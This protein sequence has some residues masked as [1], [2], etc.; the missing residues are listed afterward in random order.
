MSG[1]ADDGWVRR[2]PGGGRWRAGARR[3]VAALSGP[4]HIIRPSPDI[5]CPAAGRPVPGCCV[6]GKGCCLRAGRI[7]DGA[8]HA[9]GRKGIAAPSNFCLMAHPIPGC[10]GHKS[11]GAW[12]GMRAGV[13]GMLGGRKW[14]V[15]GLGRR[16]GGARPQL[17]SLS[18][19]VGLQVGKS[20]FRTVASHGVQGM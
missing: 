14:M 16:G 10:R 20:L 12:H 15:G 17:P 1:L 2:M 19:Y 18:C 3:G 7:G 9:A 8:R 13:M 6:A 5:M 4:S 11:C